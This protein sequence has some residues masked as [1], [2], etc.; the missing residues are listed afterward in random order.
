[1]KL[2][3]VQPALSYAPGS[4]NHDVVMRTAGRFAGQLG[5]DDVV[6]L[7]EHFDLRPE[8]EQYEEGV[9]RLARELGCHVVG[10]S[11]HEDRPNGRVNSGIVAGPQGEILGSYEKVRP[12]AVERNLVKDG[13]A[14]GE[15]VIGGHS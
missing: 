3:L 14:F 5:A 8:R 6:L 7:P 1:M 4:D 2:L 13:N 11:H 10:G 12:Y 9:R 15:F